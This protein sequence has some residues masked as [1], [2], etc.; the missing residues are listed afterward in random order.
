[1]SPSLSSVHYVT[2]DDFIWQRLP[3]GQGFRYLDGHQNPLPAE[4][5]KRIQSLVIPPAWQGVRICPDPAGHIQ[6]IGFDARGRKQYIYHPEWM[7]QNQ[8]HKFDRMIT[9][10]EVLPT[11]R[12]TIAG[13]M[14]QHTLTQERVVATVIWLLEH[15]FVRIGNREYAKSNQSYGLTTL[16]EKHV[17][18][19]GNTVQFSFKGKS[20]I[21]H[22]LD[23][24]HPRVAKTIR[25]CLEL[26]GYEIFQYLD[27]NGDRQRVDARDVNEY[28]RQITG[29]EFSAKDFRTW[30]GTTLAGDTLYQIGQPTDEAALKQA[31][32]QAVKTVSQQLRNTVTVCRKYYIH[33]TILE[34]YASEDLVPHFARI[35]RQDPSK[36]PLSPLET[37]TWTLLK[38]R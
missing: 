15:T 9:F 2:D 8:Q 10:G 12:E 28:L 20:G 34:S 30:G 17:E 14:R 6:A 1:M 13:H 23:I 21:Y 31:I 37:A 11:L 7:Q 22:E 38:K 25:Q 27:E 18:V 36:Q 29:Q 4:E 35:Y 5:K 24:R 32:T 3:H 19:E 33:P 16:R 26:P